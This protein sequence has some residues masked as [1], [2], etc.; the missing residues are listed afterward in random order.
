MVQQEYLMMLSANEVQQHLRDRLFHELCKQLRALMCNLYADA[1]ITY[2]QLVTAAWKAESEQKDCSRE[3][4]W[5][6]SVQAE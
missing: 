3:S 2:Q 6:R 4:I 5:V 1:R